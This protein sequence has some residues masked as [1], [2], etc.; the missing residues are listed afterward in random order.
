MKIK[1]EL[2]PFHFEEII[3]KGYN[4]DMLYIL[5]LAENEAD[6]EEFCKDSAK[7]KLIHQSILRKNLITSEGAL[8]LEGQE[9][10]KFLSSDDK[11]K[12]VKKKLDVEGF[13]K[14]WKTYP[15]TDNFTANGKKF[16]GSRTLRVSKDD[17]KLLINKILLEGEY[18]IDDLIGALE[19]EVKQK[20]EASL[21]EGRNK[22]SFMQNSATYLRQKTY[23]PF[24]E[25]YKTGA[26]E[27]SSQ[28]VSS[29][30]DI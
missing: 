14:W 7:L 5:K 18:I 26:A 12:I 8:S 1:L 2:T 13:E 20:V 25:L 30:I 28:K 27:E 22:L 15:G 3:K 10:M 4:L 24:I 9:L 16:T 19:L 29:T 21:K 23:E 11:R 17:C 6:I